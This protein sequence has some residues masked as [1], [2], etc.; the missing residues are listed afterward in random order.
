MEKRKFSYV[1]SL[2]FKLMLLVV[3]PLLI[4]AVAYIAIAW[5]SLHTVA[6][7]LAAAGAVE[8]P[9]LSGVRNL[10]IGVFFASLVIVY[11]PMTIAIGHLIKPL[12]LLV[13]KADQLALGDVEVATSHNRHD[14]YGMLMDSFAAVITGM[15]AQAEA[16]ARIAGGDLS[17][18]Y[19]PRSERDSV[20]YALQRMLHKNND[21]ML[22]I[23]SAAEQ[24]SVAA[25]GV[26]SG[27]QSLARGSA[28]QTASLES[29][30]EN[31]ADVSAKTA[32][33]ASLSC[34]AADLSGQTETLMSAGMAGM[35]ALTRAMEDISAASGRISD[36][37]KVIDDIA[38]QTNMLALNAS[39]EAARAGQHGKGFAVVAAEVRAL[40][41]K[42]AAAASQTTGIIGETV[43][44]VTEGSKIV[45]ESS[46]S[47]SALEK[48][49]R[50]IGA[51]VSQIAE[52]SEVQNQAIV[53]IDSALAQVAQV[54]R[55]GTSTAEEAA[56]V[57]EQMSSQARMLQEMT[58]QFKLQGQNGRLQSGTRHRALPG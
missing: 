4:V 14:E 44:K 49:S 48:N 26:A 35:E 24:V 52:A 39:V 15:R 17:F 50:E 46:A 6:G 38:F 55:L 47:M 30:T 18:D 36:V 40:A 28:E 56:S 53:S 11:P 22:S 54:V 5:N 13:D 8:Q 34:Q 45:A 32:D 43:R 33:N 27:A 20:G 41:G 10:W 51:L 2:R 29:V 7:E 31:I 21:V 23:N 42:S 3:I 37:I 58:A 16:V 12:R 25:Q 9:D 19:A 57:G 1:K